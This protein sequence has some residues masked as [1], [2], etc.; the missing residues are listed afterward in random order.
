MGEVDWWLQGHD[1]YTTKDLYS[2][3]YRKRDVKRKNEDG[4]EEEKTEGEKRDT[5]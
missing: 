1:G 4:K 2:N 3:I 5:I